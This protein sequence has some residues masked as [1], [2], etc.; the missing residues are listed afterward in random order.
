VLRSAKLK[1]CRASASSY[2]SSDAAEAETVTTSSEQLVLREDNMKL[3]R[4]TFLYLAAGAAALPAV[5]HFAW[6]ET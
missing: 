6:A 4:R 3:H 1:R 5:S 2:G